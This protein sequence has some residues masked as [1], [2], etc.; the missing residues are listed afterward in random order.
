[1]NIKLNVKLNIFLIFSILF[2]GL[3]FTLAVSPNSF[4]VNTVFSDDFQSG[5]VKWKET[6]EGDWNIETPVEKQVP[7]HTSNLV[8]HSDNCD[9][10][11]TIA[12]STPLDLRS[13]SSATITFWRYVDNDID[14]GEYLKVEL[15]DGTK[16]NTVFNWTSGAGDDDT[17]RQENVNLG[18][19]LGA[20][21]FNVRFVTKQSSA[22]EDV[23]ID[24]VVVDGVLSG[25]IT[26]SITIN[27]VTLV[28]GNYGTN[29]FIF[30]VTRTNNSGPIFA[31]YSTDNS[32]ATTQVDFIPI[33]TTTLNFAAGGP[34]TQAIAVPVIGDITVEPN[35]TFTVN[36]TTCVGCIITDN[37]GLGTITNDDS[38]PIT[39]ASPPGG[40]YTSA[41]LV[42]LSSIETAT[43]YYTVDGTTPTK[44]SAAYSNPIPLISNMV[45]KFFAT[46]DANDIPVDFENAIYTVD[47]SPPIISRNGP[48]PATVL[49]GSTYADEGATASD[50]FDGNI[51]P[52]I[53]TTNPVNTSVLG[54]YTVTYNVSDAAGNAATQ[55]TR[56]VKVTSGDI[57]THMSDTTSPSGRST[58][59]GRSL[60]SEY[61]SPTSQLV[62]DNIDSITLKLKKNGSPTGV[63]QIGVFNTD[64]SV[65]KL[66]AT[67][68]VSTLATSYVDYT[69]SLPS[70]QKYQIQ[71]GDRIGIKYTGGDSSVNV[72]TTI[73]ASTADPFDGANSY[74]MYFDTTW[75][76]FTDL[77][78]YMILKE[79]SAP[80]TGDT[81]PPVIT[82]LDSNPISV[83][84]NSSYVDAG[85]TASDNLDGNITPSIIT[86]NPVNTS[87]LGSYTVTYNVSDAA[88]NAATQVTRIVNVVDNTIPSVSVTPLS[89]IYNTSQIITLVPSDPSIIYYTTNGTTPTTASPVY[90]VPLSINTDTTLKF[91]AKTLTGNSGP[92]STK[93]YIVDTIAPVL[94]LNG[95]SEVIVD[96]YSNYLDVGATANDNRDGELTSSI[97]ISNPVNTSVLGFYTVTYNVSDAVGNVATE[98]TRIVNVVDKTPPVITLLGPNPTV[99]SQN[100]IYTELGAT[101]TDNDPTYAGIVIVGGDIVNTLVPGKY[102]IKY[103]VPDDALGNIT[104]EVTRTVYVADPLDITS[105]VISSVTP[106]PIST[107]NGNFSVYYTLSEEVV[108]GTLSFTRTDG[109]ADPLTHTYSFAE[110]DRVSG[111]HTITISSMKT[112]F[113]NTLVSDAIYT[114]TISATDASSNVADPVNHTL[115]TYDDTAP[116]TISSPPGGTYTSAQLV[117]L[118]ANEDATIYYTTDDSTPTTSSAAYTIPIPI[119]ATTTLK[120]FGKDLPGNMEQVKT[121]TYVENIPSNDVFG[122]RQIYSTKNNGNTW[123]MNMIN[124]SSDSRFDPQHAI[125]KNTDGSWK[126]KGNSAVR[127]NVFSTDKTTYE[128]TPIPTF[129][130]M[131]LT[132]NGYMQ[133]PSDWKNFEMTGYVK[134]NAG[135]SDE[136]TW[137]GRG[138]SHNDANNGCE[139]SSYKGQLGFSGGTRF[140]KES[141]HVYYDFTNTKFSTP[142]MLNKWIGFKFVIDNKPGVN[143]AQQAQGEIWVDLQNNNNW[144]KVDSFVDDGWGSGA[145]HCGPA[146]ADNMPMTWGGPEATFRA[147]NTSD[148]DFK[149]LSVREIDT[150]N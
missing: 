30:T 47:A 63:T 107:T 23:Q 62:G 123:F 80:D 68:D 40:T 86:T 106:E 129:S 51:T 117:T 96:F 74:H 136:F 8:A 4:A 13:Y 73:D 94:T 89:G 143:F 26:P 1:M 58:Y 19:Y 124:P 66:F 114:M 38:L 12:M 16:W 50:N 72:S 57:T 99:I 25:P 11:C 108:S 37:H 149:Y 137:Y 56:T 52:S 22:L 88:G 112:G 85:A 110:E 55:V 27:D 5:F 126:M 41:Q 46:S 142:S 61:V 70:G 98:V 17:W 141:W 78:L 45:I 131:Q 125:T 101:V 135:N 35:E 53:I 103:N 134:L 20:S 49:Q 84:M 7:N 9:T 48:S 15:Y 132:N 147:D 42:T 100:S 81:I 90:N 115:I 34:L 127:M 67:K 133:L 6:G 64:L 144:V 145:S 69:F 95:N 3:I 79:N 71:S 29:N 118:A 36:L 122:V 121:E 116:I 93:S 76:S 82:L 28:E 43:I 130:R 54:S 65:K 77:D 32:T 10:S 102:V 59:S 148:F 2:V 44:S 104:L 139:G 109:T 146:I 105:P 18:S 97:T 138:G 111:E 21:N 75:K 113:G 128:N 83:Q 87:V 60:H 24:D 140:A 150:P 120:F 91:F 31:N 92:V 39:I 119:S 33:Q 14:P